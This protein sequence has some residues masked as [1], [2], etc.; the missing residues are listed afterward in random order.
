MGY[1]EAT[2]LFLRSKSMKIET[3]SGR[4]GTIA[5]HSPVS[6][7]TTM[8]CLLQIYCSKASPPIIGFMLVILRIIP[9]YSVKSHTLHRCTYAY[10]K[11][12]R[13]SHAMPTVWIQVIPS[14]TM[15]KDRIQRS[16]Q[17]WPSLAVTSTVIGKI[18]SNPHGLLKQ[19]N[20]PA[21]NALAS[22]LTI[23]LVGGLNP[24]EKYY[25]VGIT[26]PNIWKNKSHVPNHQP[27]ILVDHVN[28]FNPIL[29]MPKNHET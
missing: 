25:I 4:W 23:L 5:K 7:H 6:Q 2:T 27:L 26:S 19:P 13:Y 29:A 24:S 10:A 11:T 3:N 20:A 28:R 21:P 8:G 18:H 22:V 9:R 16:S 1:V 17:V 12:R 14:H 15:L